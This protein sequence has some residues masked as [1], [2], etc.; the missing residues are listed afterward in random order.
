MEWVINMKLSAKLF[1]IVLL[2]S[3]ILIGFLYIISKSFFL[4]KVTVERNIF[5]KAENTMDFY[6]FIVLITLIIF[7]LSIFILIH[8]FVV[9]KIKIINSVVEIGRASCRERVS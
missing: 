9:R 2:V 5:K 8:V 7:S 6:F 1:R 3:L 4:V